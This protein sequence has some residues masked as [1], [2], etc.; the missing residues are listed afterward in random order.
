MH[1]GV[2]AVLLPTVGAS[3]CSPECNAR[4]YFDEIWIKIPTHMATEPVTICADDHCQSEYTSGTDTA[5]MDAD[6]M[7]D[8]DAVN[9][10]LV[11]PGVPPLDAAF[12]A[13]PTTDT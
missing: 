11:V 5:Y 10:R 4:I 1:V 3:A 12:N 9:I 7:L 13:E 6:G 8:P 2:A